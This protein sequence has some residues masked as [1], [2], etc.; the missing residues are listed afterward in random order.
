MR[1]TLLVGAAVAAWTLPGCKA[2]R[3]PGAPAVVVKGGDEAA[4]CRSCH[5]AQ[6]E[7][8]ALTA[9]AHS[10]APATEETVRGSFAPGR[11][12]LGAG[13]PPVSLVMEKR[14]GALFQVWRDTSTGTER[15]HRFDVVFGSGR[16]GQAYMYWR[17]QELMMMPACWLPR[18]GSWTLMGRSGDAELPMP[19]RCMECH[20]GG[21]LKPGEKTGFGISCASCHGEG[22]GHVA[23]H[24]A[25]PGEAAGKAIYNPGKQARE[26]SLEGCALCHSGSRVMKTPEFSWKPGEPLDA[27]LGAPMPG[28]DLMDTHGNQVGMLRRSRCFQQSPAMTCATCHDVHRTERD[29]DVLAKTCAGCH[30]TPKHRDA[31]IPPAPSAA[32]IE[33]HMPDRPTGFIRLMTPTGM[34]S[35]KYRSHAIGIYPAGAGQ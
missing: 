18:P 6:V 34:V 19:P 21:R 14:E 17:G 23:W 22:E 8:Q 32:C 26:K 13:K 9:H 33:C 16:N 28:A 29:L 30:A 2:G 5:A 24:S 12:V 27:H 25:H 31:N 15:A 10:T 4:S 7:S 35:P 3:E 20:T 11:N 1:W